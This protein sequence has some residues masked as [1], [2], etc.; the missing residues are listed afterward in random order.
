MVR[1]L[2]SG[3]SD[4]PSVESVEAQLSW[5]QV[6]LDWDLRIACHSPVQLSCPAG[7]SGE[8]VPPAGCSF[9]KVSQSFVY[10]RI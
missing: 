5:D 3:H 10:E 6:P 1:A 9:N 8:P 7:A 2:N 4:T